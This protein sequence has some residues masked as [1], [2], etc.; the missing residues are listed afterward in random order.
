MQPTDLELSFDQV[1]EILA[2]TYP[3]KT[4]TYGTNGYPSF[5]DHTRLAYFDFNNFSEAEQ[6]QKIYGGTIECIHYRDGWDLAES[7][8][9]AIE[10]MQIDVE[11]FGDNYI[12]FE[13]SSELER[14]SEICS[15]TFEQPLSFSNLSD[16][17]NFQKTIENA[18]SSDEQLTFLRVTISTF[19][20]HLR[21]YETL[22]LGQEL[23]INSDLC[24]T[25]DKIITSKTLDHHFDTHNYKI[26]LVIDSNSY[27]RLCIKGE[28]IQT[29][30]VA[31]PLKKSPILQSIERDMH[32]I[33]QPHTPIATQQ[34]TLIK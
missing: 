20:R 30:S 25:D 15:E 22:A 16:I 2:E 7:K 31:S 8:G 12:R 17:Q 23:I 10:P 33:S 26:A 27:P 14:I 32:A 24:S 9:A 11:D 4:L 34:Q 29:P 28:H 6:L 5:N 3:S 13:P 1:A 18:S 19:E 21:N